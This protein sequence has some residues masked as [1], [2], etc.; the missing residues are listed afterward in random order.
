[1]NDPLKV[2]P[3]IPKL[4]IEIPREPTETISNRPG[5]PGS[6]AATIAKA[7]MKAAAEKFDDI[8]P[9]YLEVEVPYT[10]VLENLE[11]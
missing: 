8:E 9:N 11:Q 2:G 7:K 5:G 6:L 10:N 4:I 1:V 3:K